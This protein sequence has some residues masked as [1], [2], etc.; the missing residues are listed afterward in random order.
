VVQVSWFDAVAYCQWA[1]GQLPTEAQ[2]EKAARGTD[3]QKYPWDDNPL[4]GRKANFCDSNC[5]LSW[6]DTSQDDGFS[7]TSPVGS[8]PDGA[9]PYGA[10]DMAGNVWEWVADWY[11]STYYSRSTYENPTGSTNE[12]VRAI[13]GGS[14][15][16]NLRYLRVSYRN[17]AL[18]DAG[19][20]GG[21]FRC[22]RR[23]SP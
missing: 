13:R 15:S 3:G 7:R 8:F 5:E 16:N 20:L 1:G 23:A 2:W 22:L 11:D 12:N 17:W 14:W 9:S 10:L 19:Y 4:T 6:S 21:G 18:Q